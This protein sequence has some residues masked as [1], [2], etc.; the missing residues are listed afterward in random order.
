[1]I[2]PPK[3]NKIAILIIAHS[4]APAGPNSRLASRVSRQSS[5]KDEGFGYSDYI[6]NT[7]SRL[8][9]KHTVQEE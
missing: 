6:K 4:I 9:K 2:G 5:K 1:M 7:T 3:S 8:G